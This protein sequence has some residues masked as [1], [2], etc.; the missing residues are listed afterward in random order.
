MR[1]VGHWGNAGRVW[2]LLVVAEWLTAAGDQLQCAGAL[3][4]D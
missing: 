3:V 1:L 2:P 4:Q